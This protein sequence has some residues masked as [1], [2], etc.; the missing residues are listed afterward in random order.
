[1]ANL[2][3]S[4]VTNGSGNR[5]YLE[6]YKVAGKTGTAQKVKPGERGYSQVIASFVGFV[7]TDNP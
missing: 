6:G 7:R 3:Q 5:A 2:M 1:M 4:V